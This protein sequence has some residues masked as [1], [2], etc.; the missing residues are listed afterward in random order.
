[1]QKVKEAEDTITVVGGRVKGRTALDS[2]V[3]V[4][5]VQAAEL[6]ITPSLNIADAIQSV[7]A[8]QFSGASAPEPA[9]IG[10]IAILG[11]MGFLLMRRRKS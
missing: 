9:A 2:K 3:P 7:P 10:G 5:V 8:A 1:M 4:D 6:S 11:L